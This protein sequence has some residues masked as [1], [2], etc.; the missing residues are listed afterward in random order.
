[1]E[2]F[3]REH[4][5][6]TFQDAA[7]VLDKNTIAQLREASVIFKT[8][9]PEA[10]EQPLIAY[11]V[12]ELERA[13][14]KF[15]VRM[16]PEELPE[17]FDVEAADALLAAKIAERLSERGIESSEFY[18]KIKKESARHALELLQRRGIGG[19]VVWERPEEMFERLPHA[20]TMRN[21]FALR[22][23]KSFPVPYWA[24]VR[25]REKLYQ[26]STNAS[27]FNESISRSLSSGG[28]D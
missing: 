17:D 26:E 20:R 18:E 6:E 16:N 14:G 8:D 1:M 9:I 21:A 28:A 11:I 25:D 13:W 15:V 19:I 3:S 23:F 2:E 10:L 24:L 27:A 22:F 7:R 12:E 5:A 4:A